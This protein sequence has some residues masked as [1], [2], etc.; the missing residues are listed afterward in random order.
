MQKKVLVPIADGFEEI[1]LVGIVDILRRAGIDVIIAGL[2]K[3]QYYKGAHH[4]SI[5]SDDCLMDIDFSSFDSVVLAGG[6]D[7]MQNFCASEKL[8]KVIF[9]FFQEKKLVAAIC[10][11]PV[12][13]YRAGIPLEDFTC[14]PQCETLIQKERKQENIVISDNI[15]TG[16]GPAFAIEFALAIVQYLCGTEILNQLKKELLL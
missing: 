8:L 6:W 2:D 14:Y 11:S 15:I 1:E 7:G 3:K 13:L 5:A 10:A 9:N 4:I 12:V 16:S